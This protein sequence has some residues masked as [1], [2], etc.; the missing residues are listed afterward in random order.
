MRLRSTIIQILVGA[1][2]LA[3]CPARS[4]ATDYVTVNETIW[5]SQNDIANTAGDGKKLL[6]N[7]WAKK[8][9]VELAN[10][11]TL[12]GLTVPGTSASLNISVALG[13]AYLEGRHITIPAATALTA[14]ASSTNFVWLKLTRDGA[15]LVTGAS[16][17]VT[18]SSTPPADS[19]PIATLTAGA[20]TITATADLRILPT[21]TTVLT[22]GTTWTVPAG[23]LRVEVE[24]FGA[25]GGGGGGGGGGATTAPAGSAGGAGGTTSFS[26]LSVTGGGGGSGGRGPA[27]N[28]GPPVGAPGVGSGPSANIY[29]IGRPGGQGSSGCNSSAGP[30]GIGG[31]SGAAASTLSVTPNTDI[32]YAIGAAGT[33]GAGGVGTGNS[34]CTGTAGNAGLAGAVVIHY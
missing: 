31:S 27:T 28:P 6:E 25:S 2:L 21:T 3:L 16:F 10:N 17:Q 32:T 33:G 5:P 15:S 18:T 19:T 22:T 14:S 7:Q 8:S 1:V 24:V 9:A 26:S 11:Y 30:G 12:S 34:A 20:S 4:Q 23:I 13:T 29:R